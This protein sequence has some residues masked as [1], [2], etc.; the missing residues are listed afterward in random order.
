MRQ[1]TSTS[2]KDT[3]LSG[4]V[5]RDG[6]KFKVDGIATYLLIIAFTIIVIQNHGKIPG[7]AWVKRKIKKLRS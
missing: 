1:N 4:E 6:V 7:V 3:G 2:I 5:S